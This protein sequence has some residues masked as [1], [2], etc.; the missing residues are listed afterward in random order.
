MVK[1]KQTLVASH[2]YVESDQNVMS[3]RIISARKATQKERLQY[4]SGQ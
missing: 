4:E 2:T 3:V 1:D